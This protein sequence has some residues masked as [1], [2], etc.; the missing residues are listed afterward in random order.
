MIPT[1]NSV[2]SL[3]SQ[4]FNV[5]YTLVGLR[6]QQNSS[7]AGRCESLQLLFSRISKNG[8]ISAST[9]ACSISHS[10]VAGVL[11]SF[12]EIFLCGN[13][14]GIGKSIFPELILVSSETKEFILLASGLD[15]TRLCKDASSEFHVSFRKRGTG[16]RKA[17]LA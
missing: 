8:W 10:C 9:Q 5:D 11:F 13:L 7:V 14:S 2:I 16:G 17:T 1:I 4:T 6:D 15:G 3:F 12:Q